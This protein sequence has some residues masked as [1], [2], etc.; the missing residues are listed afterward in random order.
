MISKAVILA[1]GR[2]SRL[3]PI[4][5]FLPKEMLPVMGFPAIHYVLTELADA[6]VKDVVVVLSDGKEAIRDYLTGEPAP[7]GAEASLASDIRKQTLS[8]LSISFV[9]QEELLGTAHAVSLAREFAGEDPILVVFPDD[10]LYDPKSGA[11]VPL[12]IEAL[13]DTYEKTKESVLLAAEVPGKEASQYG[14]LRLKKCGSLRLVS[15][16]VEKPLHFEEEHAFVLIGRMLLTT[17]TLDLIPQYRFSDGDGII[18]VLQKGANADALYA[19]VYRGPRYD[20]G[21]H[22]GYRSVWRDSLAARTE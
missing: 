15:E 4:T 13:S 11:A 9:R 16:I 7:K 10:L 5:P 22:Q 1:A 2:G 19:C 6:G 8:R 20:L 14:V 21:S 3:C 18:P 17:E 12:G